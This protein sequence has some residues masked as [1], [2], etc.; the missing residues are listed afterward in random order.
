MSAEL[1]LAEIKKEYHGTYKS[2]AIGFF[3]S[4]L[5]TML[6]FSL[7]ITK[8]FSNPLLIYALMGLAIIQAMVQ[9]ICFLHVGQE[10]KPRWETISFCFMG[11]VLLIIVIGSLWVMHDLNDRM[12]PEM[13]PNM[14][15]EMPHD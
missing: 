11:L 4:I 7:V 10:A 5:L 6:S 13:N 9:L 14:T 3:T 1:S 8:F 2:Y 15:E 12:M